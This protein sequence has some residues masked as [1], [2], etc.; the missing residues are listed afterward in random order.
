MYS[1][2]RSPV[3][4]H[5]MHR[6]QSYVGRNKL[7][8]WIKDWYRNRIL[9]FSI[10]E[11][12]QFW[13][14]LNVLLATYALILVC[15]RDHFRKPTSVFEIL[16]SPGLVSFLGLA[17]C[18]LRPESACSFRA[19]AP[20]R[21]VPTDD[22]FQPWLPKA[23]AWGL[24]AQTPHVLR[25][26]RV[27][28]SLSSC[29]RHAACCTEPVRSLNASPGQLTVAGVPEEELEQ[30]GK[31]RHFLRTKSELIFYFSE[32]SGEQ[33]KGLCSNQS[34][35]GLP[36]VVRRMGFSSP[37]L[38]FL[39][40]SLYLNLIWVK[41]FKKA[42]LVIFICAVLILIYFLAIKKIKE[43]KLYFLLIWMKKT[44]TKLILVAWP[45]DL[46]FNCFRPEKGPSV[47]EQCRQS[48]LEEF[49][50]GERWFFQ[51]LCVLY[52]WPYRHW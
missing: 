14:A 31:D 7:N 28:L 23:L 51:G 20:R 25:H 27:Q 19:L 48:V 43:G 11:T 24:P 52:R 2:Q 21:R 34:T 26:V 39:T 30:I 5:G 17:S 33:S 6:C 16:S 3:L 4:E 47:V 44:V 37:S 9:K 29:P 50:T 45:T 12:K 22:S 46:G 35:S 38:Y 8:F 42:I 1:R 36:I 18:S 32:R 41:D 40:Y 15:L 13:I 10:F 49:R